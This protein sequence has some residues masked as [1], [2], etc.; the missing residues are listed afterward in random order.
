M[1]RNLAATAIHNRVNSPRKP[2]GEGVAIHPHPQKQIALNMEP[3]E[4][5]WA[6]GEHTETKTKQ[7]NKKMRLPLGKAAELGPSTG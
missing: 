7:T 4:C 6:A 5:T 3:Q 1:Q 2:D